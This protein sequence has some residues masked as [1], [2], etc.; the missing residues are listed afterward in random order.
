MFTSCIEHSS[1]ES[2]STSTTGRGGKIFSRDAMS[3]SE[4]SPGAGNTTLKCTKSFPLLNGWPYVGMPSSNTALK[5]DGLITSPSF[6]LTRSCL[7]S[8]CVTVVLN[9]Q[10]ASVREMSFSRNKSLPLRLKTACSFSCTTKT[11]SPGTVPGASSASPWNTIF[12]LFTMP[13]SM[14]TSRT[15]FSWTT[16]W[17]W[18]WPHLS[19]S[20]ITWPVPRHSLHTVCIC[21]TMPGAICRTTKRTPLPLH[22]PQ[23][24]DAPLLLPL[25]SHLGQSTFFARD[26]FFVT[27][28]YSSSKLTFNP[29]TTSSPFRWR[30]L[31]PPPP[32]LPPNGFPPNICS[33]MS[34]G[35]PPPP[36]PPPPPSFSPSSP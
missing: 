25:P 32:R 10:S 19:F 29:C 34:N 13:F 16:F 31:W 1:C 30:C 18:H 22:E 27:P 21:C 20:E 2:V 26:S 11:I 17:A 3:S 35:E 36:P 8:R 9:P 33:K 14:C 15:F 23:C 24:P 6:V 7:L 12:W 5:D 4:R 28:L